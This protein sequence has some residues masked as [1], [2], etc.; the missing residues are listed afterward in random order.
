MRAQIYAGNLHTGGAIVG[1]AALLDELPSLH[2]AHELDWLEQLT[3]V[4]STAVARNAMRLGALEDLPRTVL[5]VR[6]DRPRLAAL[7]ARAG[8][9]QFDVRFSFRGPEYVGRQANRE[10]VGFAD[11]S[12]FE[13][14]DPGGA[15]V[16][17]RSANAVKRALL[18][19]YDEFVVQTDLMR[20]IVLNH[21]GNKPVTVIPNSPSPVFGRDAEWTTTPLPLRTPGRIRLFY[22]ARAYPHKNHVLIAP[23]VH[24]LRAGWG[25]EAEVVT[26]LHPAEFEAL[27]QEVRLCC[28]N[29]GEVPVTALPNLYLETDGVFFPSLNETS[30]A[31]PLEGQL[32]RRPVFASD[33]P[34][35][36]SPAGSAPF[37]FTAND[38]VDAARVVGTYFRDPP[39]YST[40]LRSG[41]AFARGLPSPFERA[42]LSMLAMRGSD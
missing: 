10:L 26:T 4:A 15:S 22:P 30:S 1:A 35:I 8:A 34:F 37:Y 39:T 33:L 32:M 7:W 24:Q 11:R 12:M 38:P 40:R 29:V 3:V 2:D 19:R 9:E 21:V 25:L 5:L 18:R 16:R 14:A 23:M 6:D 13:D 31:T 42:R 27:P 17:A 41:L 28:V 36:R 20:R